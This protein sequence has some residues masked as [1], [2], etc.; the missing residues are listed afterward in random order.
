MDRMDCLTSA[1]LAAVEQ[2]GNDLE[3]L[4]GLFSCYVR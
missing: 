1:Y 2:K 3:L 4:Q